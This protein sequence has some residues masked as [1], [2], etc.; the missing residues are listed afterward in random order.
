ML[1]VYAAYG[2]EAGQTS[3]GVG[4]GD[5]PELGNLTAY[6]YVVASPSTT[7]T[8]TSSVNPQ[9]T[10]NNVTF[11]ATVVPIP[12]GV[13]GPTGTVSF[14]D[15]TT[16]LG[17]GTLNLVSGSYIATYTTSSLALGTHT[18]KASYPGGS[19][20]AGSSGTLTQT[21]VRRPNHIVASGG[22]GQTTVYGTPFA[23][24]LVVTVTDETGAGVPNVTVTFTGTGLSF[25]PLTATTNASGIAQVTANP[26]ATG[27]LT[28]T[29]SVT[30]VSTPATF[31]L[32]ATQAVLT[33]K[34]NDATRI[35]GQP[36]P[37]F[38]ALITGFVNGDTQNAP[39]P[40]LQLCQRQQL[41]R[42]R[43]EPIRSS[44]QPGSLMAANYTFSFVNGNLVITASPQSMTTLSVAPATVV[45]GDEVVLTA[46]VTP[47]GATGLVRF[48]DGS[49]NL[50]GSASVDGTGTAVLPVSHTASRHT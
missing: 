26:T 9:T 47:S 21:I 12:L 16:L 15:G 27:S 23:N 50:G 7:T 10:G 34:A 29:A 35:F 43:W 36:N 46:V 44:P 13:T 48:F 38:T 45:Y 32:T 39:S 18:I 1:F 40:A 19:A 31:S 11:T 24:P 6:P 5:S 33:V 49:S 37:T 42:L 2:N 3:G 22:G 30:G 25:T 28:A 4:N 8:V 17:T 20:Y 41:R 14:F